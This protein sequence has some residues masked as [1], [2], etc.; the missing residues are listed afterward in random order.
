MIYS[1]KGVLELNDFA[2][3]ENKTTTLF[4]NITDPVDFLDNEDYEDFRNSYE[5]TAFKSDD[6]DM[7]EISFNMDIN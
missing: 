5:A 6:S 7:G 2:V 1:T 3:F 4:F